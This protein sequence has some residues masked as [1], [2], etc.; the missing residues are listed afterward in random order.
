MKQRLVIVVFYDIGGAFALSAPLIVAICDIDGA[1]A[2]SA[3]LIV[4]F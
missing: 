1:F 3:P 4:A 2:L